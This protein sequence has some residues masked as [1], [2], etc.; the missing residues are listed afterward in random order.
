MKLV[1]I[2]LLH[3][4]NEEHFQLMSEVASLIKYAPETFKT[5]W[6]VVMTISM[7]LKRIKNCAC[8]VRLRGYQNK[9]IQQFVSFSG[10][11]H[12]VRNDEMLY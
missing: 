5:K 7:P 9:A 3:L 12:F 8:F 6:S 11:L 1:K 2:S 4:R 10:L